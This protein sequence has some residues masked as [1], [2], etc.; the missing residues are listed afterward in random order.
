MQ[1]IG[2]KQTATCREK[3][4]FVTLRPPKSNDEAASGIE[5]RVI[6]NIFGSNRQRKVTIGR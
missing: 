3:G 2:R 5:Q 1:T 4:E 6:K